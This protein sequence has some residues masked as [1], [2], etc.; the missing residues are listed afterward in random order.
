SISRAVCAP[1]LGRLVDRLGQARVM[2]WA[3]LTQVVF[4]FLLT[5]GVVGG[6]NVVVLVVLAIVAGIGTGSPPALVRAR[7]SNL[8]QDSRSLT[9]AFSW[10]SIVEETAFIVGPVVVALIVTELS[11]V[12]GVA[13]AVGC[14]A[15]GSAL[16]YSQ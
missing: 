16:L 6:W 11:P 3:V 7:W 4:L 14:L 10:E 13:F 5:V 12:V 8:V 15:A 2:S 9:T 1:Y